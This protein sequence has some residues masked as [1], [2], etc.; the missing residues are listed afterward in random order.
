MSYDV[1]MGRFIWDCAEIERSLRIR[2]DCGQGLTW[3]TNNGT[4]V[5]FR[6]ATDSA[7]KTSKRRPP[8]FTG[9]P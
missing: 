8:V 6:A 5:T 7:G 4:K 9:S 2:L 1:F 3:R